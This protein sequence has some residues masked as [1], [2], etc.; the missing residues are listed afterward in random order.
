MNLRNSHAVSRLAFIA[1]LVLAAVIGVAATRWVPSDEYVVQTV[2]AAAAIVVVL[3]A[4]ASS[5]VVM[6]RGVLRI[7]ARARTERI[8]ETV[9]HERVWLIDVDPALRA[10]VSAHPIA[11]SSPTPLS[12]FGAH[13]SAD[14]HGLTVWG[15]VG[16]VPEKAA[17]IGWAEIVQIRPPAAADFIGAASPQTVITIPPRIA[18]TRAADTV[19]A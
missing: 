2:G 14:E 17:A 9:P 8:R 6:Y 15:G 19:P 18:G 16:R 4:I 13:I 5:G 11:G 1:G 3:A 7:P 12:R 10:R